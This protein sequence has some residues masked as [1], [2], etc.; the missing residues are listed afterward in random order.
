[1]SETHTHDTQVEV[2]CINMARINENAGGFILN[3][4]ANN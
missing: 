4:A 2:L 3:T 1:M